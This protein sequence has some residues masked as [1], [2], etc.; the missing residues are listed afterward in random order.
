M[1]PEPRDH[2]IPLQAAAA[3]TRRFRQGAAKGA[4]LGELFGRAAVEELLR[5]PGCEGIR[6]YHGRDESGAAVVVLV[7]VDAGGADMTAGAILEQGLP[8][9]PWCSAG[10]PLGG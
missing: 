4:V 5:Q 10:S 2:H 1:L 6:I 3:L 9:P 7:G 8:C